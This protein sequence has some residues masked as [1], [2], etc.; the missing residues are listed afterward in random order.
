[1]PEQSPE[2]TMARLMTISQVGLEMAAPIGLGAA[3]DYWLG[4]KAVFMI[5][6]AVLGFVGGVYHLVVL[7]RPGPK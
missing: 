1:M 7:N 3:L 6:G 5:V 2:R 4:T